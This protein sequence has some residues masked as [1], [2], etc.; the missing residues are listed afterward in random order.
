VPSLLRGADTVDQRAAHDG[1]APWVARGAA[2]AVPL[3]AKITRPHPAMATPM[4][5]SIDQPLATNH[6]ASG[7][8]R[9]DESPVSLRSE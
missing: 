4:L 9:V 5:L 8:G 7:G 1:L 3:V 2:A 6:L